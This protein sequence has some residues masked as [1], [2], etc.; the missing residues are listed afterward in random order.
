MS[1]EP[2]NNY[3]RA[4]TVKM[5]YEAR[6]MSMANV[7]GV[8]VGVRQRGGQILDEIALIVLVDRKRPWSE[9]AP[10]D[11]VPSQLDGVPVDVQE[12]GRPEAQSGKT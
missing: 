7:V 4:L 12:I 6:L 8:G 10:E 9:L 1:D 5:R 11:R 2:S 3:Q